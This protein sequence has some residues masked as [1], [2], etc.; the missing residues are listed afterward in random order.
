MMATLS[1]QASGGHLRVV[2]WRV[3]RSR[4][5]TSGVLLVLLGI[6]GGLIPFVGPKFNY[7]YTPD[8]T[9]TMTSGRLWLEVL[10]GAAALLGGLIMLGSTNRAA[11]VFGGWLAAVA[12]G[13]FVV[14]PS[15]SILWGHGQSQTGLPIATT[16]LGTMVQQIGF[17]YGLGVVI[18]FLAAT[19]LG[20][21]SIIGARDVQAAEADLAAVAPEPAGP[22]AMRDP[23]DEPGGQ[24]TTVLPRTSAGR[25]DADRGDADRTVVGRHGR[26]ADTAAERRATA[27]PAGSTPTNSDQS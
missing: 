25:A 2:R 17:F 3:P 13:W 18:L 1:S 23:I 21:L 8:V 9:W 16:P 19:A 4:G 14:G 5:A 22:P 27:T 20:R 7:A 6:W 12:G 10:P 24:A 15:V 26:G 11:A